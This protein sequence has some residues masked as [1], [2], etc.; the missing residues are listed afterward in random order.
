MIHKLDTVEVITG[1][2]K[3]KQGRVLRVNLK[4]NKVLVENV[5]QKVKHVKAELAGIEGTKTLITHPIHISNVALIDPETN[6]PTK[7]KYGFLEDGTKV[8][9]SKTSGAVIP[10]AINVKELVRQ[11]RAKKEDGYKDTP[12]ELALQRSYFGEDFAAIKQK[13]DEYIIDKEKEAVHLV[14]PE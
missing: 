14:F 11:R 1:K 5:N 6:K 10:S 4:L 7:V 9:V 13:F 3:G 2:D 8:R 12:T